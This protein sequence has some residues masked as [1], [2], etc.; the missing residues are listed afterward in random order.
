[1]EVRR[2]RFKAG[3]RFLEKTIDLE[4]CALIQTSLTTV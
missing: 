3:N 4:L 1:M 2:Q